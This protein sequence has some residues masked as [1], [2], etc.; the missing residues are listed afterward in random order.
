MLAF[1]AT[2]QAAATGAVKA[3]KL[4]AKLVAGHGLAAGEAVAKPTAAG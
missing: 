2:L 1:G 4:S 3:I